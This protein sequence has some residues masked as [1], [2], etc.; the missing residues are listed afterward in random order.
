ME[1][2]KEALRAWLEIRP[3]VSHDFVFLSMRDHRPLSSRA[4]TEIVRRLSRTAGL[5]RALGAHSLRHRV[6]LKFAREHVA[7]RIAQHYL[8]HA[9]IKTTLEYYQDIDDADVK[10]ASKLLEPRSESDWQEEAKQNPAAKLLKLRTG[11]D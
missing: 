9:N 7:P 2:A 6:G 4:V 10:L 3:N 11:S 5:K 8:G 1:P